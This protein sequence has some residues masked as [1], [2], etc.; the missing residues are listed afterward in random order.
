MPGQDPRLT[1]D[2]AAP[3]VNKGR[4]KEQITLD[5]VGISGGRQTVDRGVAHGW[6]E[7]G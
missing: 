6:T 1:G 4:G 5:K 7:T 2:W 3:S